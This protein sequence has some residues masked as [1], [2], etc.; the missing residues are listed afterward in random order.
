MQTSSRRDRAA[1][2]R[3]RGLGGGESVPGDQGEEL[4]VVL[5][6]STHRRP[7][8]SSIGTAR[9]L[10]SIDLNHAGVEPLEQGASS[11][12]RA[13]LV[14]QKIPCDGEQP[15]GRIIKGDLLEATP[16]HFEGGSDQIVGVGSGEPAV[17]CEAVQGWIARPEERAEPLD[18][19]HHRVPVVIAASVT[20]FSGWSGAAALAIRDC[21]DR[22]GLN[23]DNGKG[24][25]PYRHAYA[26]PLPDR[27][28][29]HTPTPV[30]TS[31]SS[32]WRAPSW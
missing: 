4:A 11:L 14:P 15:G 23:G 2:E 31:S 17:A 6:E 8:R 5:C 18:F 22:E 12:V 1:A 30:R 27:W 9:C 26:K 13:T 7:D 21:T 16:R 24:L 10:A 20:R 32:G 28:L 19:V 25:M 29:G 3:D